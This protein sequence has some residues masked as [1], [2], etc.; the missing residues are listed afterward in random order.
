VEELSRKVGVVGFSGAAV[1][2]EVDEDDEEEVEGVVEG[3]VGVKEV[4]VNEVEEE[5]EGLLE[6]LD[7]PP[8]T[9]LSACAQVSVERRGT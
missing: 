7:E 9:P 4:E 5:P 1:G 8:R 2:E 3:V 6:E